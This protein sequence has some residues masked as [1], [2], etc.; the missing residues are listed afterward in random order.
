LP[1]PS[2]RDLPDP[3]IEP[4]YLALQAYSLPTELQGK[5]HKRLINHKTAF[6][7][8]ILFLPTNMPAIS[9]N[10]NW[11]RRKGNLLNDF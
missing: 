11:K 7:L 3:G 4:R 1:F 9:K 5:N 6:T 2:P 8:Y 10:I